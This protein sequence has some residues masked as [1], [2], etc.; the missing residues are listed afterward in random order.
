VRNQQVIFGYLHPGH[1][2]HC[3]S[4]SVRDLL[5]YDAAHGQHVVSHAYGVAPKETGASHIIAGRNALARTLLDQ[6]DAGWLL[7]ID[8][9]M[10][11]APDTVERLLAAADPIDRPVVGGLAFAQKSDGVGPMYA[12]RY[13][14]CPTLYVM[15]ET[16]TEVGFVPIFDYPRDSLVE[17]DATGAA[18][19]LIHRSVFDRIER[20]SGARPFDQ[21]S[22][23]KGP[24]GRTD[25]GEDLSFSLRAKAVGAAIHVDTSIKTTHDKGAV[26]LDEETYDLQQAMFELRGLAA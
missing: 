10:G 12:R 3:F 8:A 16:D 9:D 26:F 7:M 25:F 4:A 11:F 22:V 19:L 2:S 6:H 15:H 17:V 1:E 13:R 24:T 5:F 20:E 21:V 14:M 18:C 23:P